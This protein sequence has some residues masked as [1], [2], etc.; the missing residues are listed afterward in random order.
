MH[1]IYERHYSQLGFDADVLEIQLYELDPV[2]DQVFITQ[3]KS[4][5]GLTN[6][7]FS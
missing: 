1:K 7:I 2:V 3:K 5:S 6:Q 4:P